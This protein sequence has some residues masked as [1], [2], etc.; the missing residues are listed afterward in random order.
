MSGFK[1]TFTKE[2]GGE[3]NLDYD[4]SAFYYFAGVIEI[5]V[6][7]PLIYTFIKNRIFGK[8]VEGPSI[9][10]LDKMTRNCSCSRCKSIQ[11]L[12][13]THQKT[14]SRRFGF[15]GL[16]HLL[17]IVLFL[18]LAYET[19]LAIMSS[20][21][22]IKRF[23]PYEILGIQIGATDKEIKKAFREMSRVFHPD[24]NP[25]NN[26]AAGKYIQITKAYET[27]TNELARANYEKYGNPDGP[28]PVKVTFK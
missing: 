16:F 14:E 5:L 25:G 20:P 17:L 22:G 23:D 28:S 19:Y 4:D 26:W 10:N 15:S 1:E 7:L 9:S 24:K 6:L 27:L 12:R 8:S 11:Q 18:Y 2:E 3:K 13:I 21:E